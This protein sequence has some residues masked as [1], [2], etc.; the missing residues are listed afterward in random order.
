MSGPSIIIGGE[1]QDGRLLRNHLRRA[2]RDVISV[3]RGAT[4]ADPPRAIGPVDVLDAA[5]VSGL[6]GSTKPAEVY[7]LAAYHHAAEA[8]PPEPAEL[9]RRSFAIHVDG[10]VNV[11]EAIRTTSPATRLFYAA[12]SHVFGDAAGPMQDETTPLQPRCAYGITKAAGM[13]CC[14]LYRSAHGVFA[15]VG[16]LYN[17]ESSLRREQFVSQKIVRAAVAAARGSREKLVLGDLSARIDWGYAPDFVDAMARILSLDRPDD[18]VIATGEA[19][20]VGEF[21]TIAYEAVGLE[22]AAYVEQDP[23]ILHKPGLTLIGDSA[24]LRAATGWKPSV[25]FQQMVQALVHAARTQQDAAKGA[26]HPKQ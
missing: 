20:T 3:D 8:A 4:R 10:V 17:H 25:T 6:I 7:Y 11:L 21:A 24:K 15:S 16:I 5:A 19:H 13:Q 18:F 2:R 22:A 12:S 26:E 9:L 14:R 1:G 23:S